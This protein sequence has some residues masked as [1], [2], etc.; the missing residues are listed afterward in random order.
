MILWYLARAAGIT[1]F[2]CL[3][4]ATGLGALTARN[5][6][7]IERRVIWQYMHRTAAL[8]GVALIGLHIVTLLADPYANVGLTGLLPFGSGYRPLAVT[9]GVL[10]LY[11]VVAVMVTGL[12]RGRIA[13]SVAGA[14]RWRYVHITAYAA[15]AASAWHFLQAGSDSGSWWARTVL[16]A[17][18][19]V[20]IAGVVAGGVAG[21]LRSSRPAPTVLVRGRPLDRPSTIDGPKLDRPSSL[22]RSG[23]LPRETVGARR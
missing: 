17:G 15:W 18:A 20:V 1:A 6:A 8:I 21:R 2:A 3:S 12:L 4:I 13:R 9:F 10:S 16:V 19:L 5:G 14:R 23:P 7:R 11:L 22:D